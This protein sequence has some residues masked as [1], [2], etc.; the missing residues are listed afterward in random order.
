MLLGARGTGLECLPALIFKEEK[1]MMIRGYE[2]Y[3]S[4][5]NPAAAGLDS[6]PHTVLTVPQFFKEIWF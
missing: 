5:P 6:K 4:D 1:G 3:A 2:A